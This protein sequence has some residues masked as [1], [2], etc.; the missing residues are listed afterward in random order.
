MAKRL[1]RTQWGNVFHNLSEL[2]D[3]EYGNEVE[4][5]YMDNVPGPGE[6][7][8]CH[9]EQLFEDGFETEYDA[10]QR[11]EHVLKVVDLKPVASICISNTGGVI[12]YECE[13]DYVL[14]GVN[15]EVPEYY[16]V[17]YELPEDIDEDADAVPIF[18]M[19]EWELSL[20]DAM[21]LNY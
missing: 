12:I 6:W 17:M 9:G 13:S 8:L 11:L 18:K 10:E 14:A 15:D 5:T 19:G 3:S 1:N 16:E 4:V 21:R 2:T 7:A 20:G